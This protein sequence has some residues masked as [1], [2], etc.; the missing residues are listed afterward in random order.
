M[1]LWIRP[2]GREVQ[3]ATD[4]PELPRC[5]L[6]VEWPAGESES[7]RFWLSELPDHTPL[8]ALVRVANVRWC[9]EHDY[10]EMK[11]ALGLAHFEGRAWNGWHHHVA[12]VSAA[13]ASS[14]RAA[15]TAVMRRKLCVRGVCATGLGM[16]VVP[17]VCAITAASSMGLSAGLTRGAPARAASGRAPGARRSSSVI[18]VD[19]FTV[20]AHRRRQADVRTAPL[21]R[22]VGRGAL[23]RAVCL[24][25]QKE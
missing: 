19:G 17:E 24:A 20:A 18:G 9:F 4:G 8:T 5:W 21:Y 1:A 11:Q 12:L 6:L 25:G 14:R 13:H 23:H 3:Q 22:C 15:V 16:P 10:R 2:A 7:V